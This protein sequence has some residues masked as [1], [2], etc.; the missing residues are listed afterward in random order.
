VIDQLR[1]F[2]DEG[3]E[4]FRDVLAGFR[5]NTLSEFPRS[6]LEDANLTREIGDFCI[7]PQQFESKLEAAIYLGGLISEI[8]NNYP[9]GNPYENVGLWSWLSAYYFDQVCPRTSSGGRKILADERHILNLEWGRFYRHLLAAPV[10]MYNTH[11]ESCMILLSGQLDEMGEFVEQLMSRQDIALNP[12]LIEGANALYWDAEKSAP[13]RGV[14]STA[15]DPG[16]LRRFVDVVQQLDLTFDLYSM[17]RQEILAI[18]PAEFHKF[19]N[20][21]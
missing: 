13:R 11:G 17:T 1:R 6:L 16:T 5:E 2:T 4:K 19:L 9:Q 12:S 21:G 14:R 8:G 20:L 3:V 7:E 15:H 10:R 18:L